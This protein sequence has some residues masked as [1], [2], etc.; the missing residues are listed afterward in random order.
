MNTCIYTKRHTYE[1]KLHN[2]N[3]VMRYLKAIKVKHMVKITTNTQTDE[4]V[5]VSELS[6]GVSL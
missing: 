1:N 6:S 4:N 5:S 2:N 3:T